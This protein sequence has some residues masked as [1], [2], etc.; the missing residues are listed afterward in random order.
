MEIAAALCAAVYVFSTFPINVR[1]GYAWAS[2]RRACGSDLV[3]AEVGKV[4]I[5]VAGLTKLFDIEFGNQ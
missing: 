5:V 2:A 1:S 3:A 4:G